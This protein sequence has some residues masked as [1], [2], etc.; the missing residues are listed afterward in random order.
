MKEWLPVEGLIF[1]DSNTTFPQGYE[2]WNKV[3]AINIKVAKRVDIITMV[4]MIIMLATMDINN[5]NV[6]T[7]Y[8]SPLTIAT[9]DVRATLRKD[10]KTM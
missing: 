2:I 8:L 3:K 10:N 9:R 4:M 6:I 1:L 5:I 7:R